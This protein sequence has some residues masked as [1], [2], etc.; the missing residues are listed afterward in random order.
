MHINDI[1]ATIHAAM[2][3]DP[4]FGYTMGATRWGTGGTGHLTVTEG[5]IKITTAGRYRITASAYVQNTATGSTGRGVYVMRA[6]S[7]EAFS[8]ATE[9]L[10]AMDNFTQ[11]AGGICA[12]PKILALS[13]NDIIYLAARSTGAAGTCDQDNVSTYLLIE[14]L[15]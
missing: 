15:S 3:N 13:A 4:G 2:C 11:S 1:G 9:V 12:G 8:A 7:S 6:T 14:R 10:S 5:G